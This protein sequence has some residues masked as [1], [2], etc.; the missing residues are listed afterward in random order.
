MLERISPEFRDEEGFNPLDVVIE[1]MKSENLDSRKQD[2][3]TDCRSMESAMDT[4]VA[5]TVTLHYRMWDLK[6][7]KNS[8][9]NVC[10]FSLLA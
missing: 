7:A 10:F 2:L 1:I 9:Q 6:L 3:E 4:I 8:L 5:G